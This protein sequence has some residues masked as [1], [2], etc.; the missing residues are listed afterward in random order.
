MNEKRST[1]LEHHSSYRRLYRELRLLRLGSH[2][3]DVKYPDITFASELTTATLSGHGLS[4]QKVRLR[5]PNDDEWSFVL[6]VLST[7]SPSETVGKTVGMFLLDTTP[8]KVAH[9][10]GNLSIGR[11]RVQL[12]DQVLSVD[13]EISDQIVYAW[14][15]K[16]Q[17]HVSGLVVGWEGCGGIALNLETAL[18]TGVPAQ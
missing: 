13:S 12:K 16:Q 11:Y 6:E 3:P 8:A 18:P 17:Q 14:T 7:G 2:F 5:N 1:P 15:V 4:Q 9:A 10:P